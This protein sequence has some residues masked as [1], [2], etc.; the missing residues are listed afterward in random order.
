MNYGNLIRRPFD[1][2]AR[3]P[4]LW[5]LGLLAGGATTFNYFGGNGSYRTNSNSTTIYTGPSTATFQAFWNNNWEWL[6]GIAAFAAVVFVILFILGSIATGGII[7]AAVEHDEGRDYQLGTAWRAGYTTLWRIAGLRLAT[8]V[9]AIAPAVFI[10]ALVGA[11]VAMSGPFV[12][13][14]VLF[15]L[16]AAGVGVA[17]IFFWIALGIAYEF[18]QRL[19]VIEGARVFDA[20]AEGFRM[21]PR[22]GKEVALGW[23]ILIAISIVA[24]IAAVFLAIAVGIPAGIIGFGGWLAAGTTGAII[25]GSIAAV[26]FVGVLLAA[27]GAYAAYSSVYWTLLFRT[28]RAMPAPATRSAMVPAA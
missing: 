5:L 17:S 12:P 23:L 11:T 6:V 15:G 4:Y 2:V 10:G 9:L 16:L 28:V 26:F 24:G 1:I 18:A 21:I 13:G 25:T 20:I 14:A 7:R 27:G 8:F 19:I 3:R 22:H